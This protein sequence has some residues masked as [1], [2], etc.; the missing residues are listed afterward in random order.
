[1]YTLERACRFNGHTLELVHTNV[2]PGVCFLLTHTRPDGND[3]TWFLNSF[4]Q[5]HRYYT[6]FRKSIREDSREVIS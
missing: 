1:M 2:L 6:C 5:A 4:P 3:K